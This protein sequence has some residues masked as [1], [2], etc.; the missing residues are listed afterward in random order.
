RT[1]PAWP[2]PSR[3]RTAATAPARR[4]RRPARPRPPVDRAARV[5]AHRPVRVRMRARGDRPHHAA[6]LAAGQPGVRGLGDHR[7]RVQRDLLTHLLIPHGAPPSGG[8][9]PE[10]DLRSTE[11]VHV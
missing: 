6:A 9:A 2:A 5:P 3:Y 7:P 4:P 1:A 11:A 10:L 8:L